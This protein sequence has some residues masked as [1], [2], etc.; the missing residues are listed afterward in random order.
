LAVTSALAAS[1]VAAIVEIGAIIIAAPSKNTLR[2]ISFPQLSD[3]IFTTITSANERQ[4]YCAPSALKQLHGHITIIRSQPEPKPKKKGGTL[5][6]T[7]L[8]KFC[9]ATR[10]LA[11]V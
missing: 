3:I 7:A 9:G 2:I 6:D 10:L 11:V 1:L 4:L 8:L 5:S